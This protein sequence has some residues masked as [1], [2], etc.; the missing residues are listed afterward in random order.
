METPNLIIERNGE[1]PT[2]GMCSAC[3][4]LFPT[5]EWNGA[6]ANRRLVERAFQ[7]HVEAEHSD[8]SPLSESTQGVNR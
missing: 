8:Q 2:S 1:S 4:A 5:V 6:E 7:R 3:R